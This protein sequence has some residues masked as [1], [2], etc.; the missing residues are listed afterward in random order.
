[1]ASDV[2]ER[3]L[4]QNLCSLPLLRYGELVR[5]LPGRVSRLV[6]RALALETGEAFRPAM[7]TVPFPVETQHQVL[8]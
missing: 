6:A 5:D 8:Q 2:T 4:R 7:A 3:Y 1:M